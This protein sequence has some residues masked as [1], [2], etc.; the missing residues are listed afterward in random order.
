M[1]RH[2]PVGLTPD[3]K[4]NWGTS[5]ASTFLVMGVDDTVVLV[6]ARMTRGTKL[7]RNFICES[8]R[9]YGK[10]Y[11][12][13]FQT[14]LWNIKTLSVKGRKKYATQLV[15]S[16]VER[17]DKR[18]RVGGDETFDLCFCTVLLAAVENVNRS[19]SPS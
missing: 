7:E 11:S 14:G 13:N 16:L 1:D 9:Y 6:T 17:E 4:P 18:E 15:R 2:A 3:E 12:W 19:L 8:C 10:E 5:A